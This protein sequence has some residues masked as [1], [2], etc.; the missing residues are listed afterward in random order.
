MIFKEDKHVYERNSTNYT[1]VTT[2]IGKYKQGF[3]QNYWTKYK[4]YQKLLGDDKFK[5]IKYE[6]HPNYRTFDYTDFNFFKFIDKK[7]QVNKGSL[8]QEIKELKEYYKNESLAGSKKGTEYHDFK[9][10]QAIENKFIYHPLT[11]KKIETKLSVNKIIKNNKKIVT[12]IT[13]DLFTLEDGYYPEM[14][15][16]NDIYKISGQAD[17]VFIETIDDKR[18]VTIDD[19]KSN[20]KISKSGLNK[21]K[22]PLSHLS[23]C[24]YNH[25]RLQI[26]MYGWLL[27]QF[28]FIVKDTMFTHLNKLYQFDYMETEV[29]AIL[30]DIKG[31]TDESW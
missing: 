26:S 1:S 5:Q 13:E 19:W 14:L 27:S 17:K 10:A 8:K 4:S 28:G 29:N 20:K 16:W 2:L 15:L 31:G 25:Y 6:Y 24:N 18:Y 21:M 7:V 9:E 12:S 23:D 3:D 30:V 22:P 11:N